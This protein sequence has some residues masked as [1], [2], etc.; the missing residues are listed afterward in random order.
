VRARR[1]PVHL[2][3]LESG[4]V[5]ALGLDVAEVATEREHLPQQ[6]GPRTQRLHGLGEL[7]SRDEFAD[8]LLGSQSTDAVGSPS[9]NGASPA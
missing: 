3:L 8:V 1:S 5:L 2:Q 6:L 9:E 4:L 7:R